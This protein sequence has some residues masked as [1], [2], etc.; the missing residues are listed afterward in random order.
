MHVIG[1]FADV[2]FSTTSNILIAQ[3][4]KEFSRRCGRINPERIAGERKLGGFRW[5]P[6]KEQPAEVLI[7]WIERFSRTFLFEDRGGGK[8]R[9]LARRCKAGIKILN[10]PRGSDL[11]SATPSSPPR[12]IVIRDY[13]FLLGVS[14][15]PISTPVTTN[16]DVRGERHS[17]EQRSPILAR[18]F[19]RRKI[20]RQMAIDGRRRS[21]DARC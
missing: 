15:I 13:Y 12:R 10:S 9:W 18:V 3:L 14:T 16:A 4:V 8:E 19:I 20:D 2:L 11:Q 5:Y 21:P 17:P 6:R 1:D 7:L